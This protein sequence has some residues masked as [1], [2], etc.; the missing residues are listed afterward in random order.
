MPSGTG[1]VAVR[2]PGARGWGPALQPSGK[3]Q[4]VPVVPVYGKSSEPISHQRHDTLQGQVTM[5]EKE[6]ASHPMGALMSFRKPITDG[7]GKPVGKLH[8]R[9]HG[10]LG[11]LSPV[12]AQMLPSADARDRTAAAGALS[13]CESKHYILF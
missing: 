8:R 4:Q 11:K 6:A 1:P 10:V 5:D 12:S 9:P 13:G 3:L 2:C 7:G